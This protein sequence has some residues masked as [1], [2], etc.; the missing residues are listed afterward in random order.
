MQVEQSILG[1]IQKRQ[2]E[3][4]SSLMFSIIQQYNILNR[5]I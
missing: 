3:W 2:M 4:I 1:R 5:I